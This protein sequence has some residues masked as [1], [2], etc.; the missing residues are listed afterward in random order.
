MNHRAYY[1]N[2]YNLVIYLFIIYLFI[3]LFIYS[4]IYL[5]SIYLFIYTFNWQNLN[6][7]VDRLLFGFHDQYGGVLLS[8]KS[9]I[10]KHN[11][12]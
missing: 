6:V 10:F 4:F 1:S 8:G 9:W 5:F 2:V 7:P 12:S 3:Y 11:P